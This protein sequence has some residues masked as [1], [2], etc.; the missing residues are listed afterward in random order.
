MGPAEICKFLKT[1][2]YDGRKETVKPIFISAALT[3]LFC[4]FYQMVWG[5]G[6]ADSIA[7][8]VYFYYGA[9]WATSNGRWFIRILNGFIGRNVVIP[10]VAVIG[11]VLL[12]ALAAVLIAEMLK[13][14]NKASLVLMTAMLVASPVVI[15]QLQYLYIGLSYGAAFLLS[16]LSVY[17]ILLKPA[18]RFLKILLPVLS[19]LCIT[20]MLGIYQSY[21]GAAAM[22]ILLVA[23][24]KL[25]D[26]E[27]I[28]DIFLTCLKYLGSGVTGGILDLVI[29]KTIMKLQGLE[30]AERVGTF[31]LQTI[32]GQLSDSLKNC[33]FNLFSYF[34]DAMMMRRYAYLV[35]FVTGLVLLAAGLVKLLRSGKIASFITILVLLIVLPVFI[36]ITGVIF[37]DNGITNIM[38]YQDV[39]YI[40]L[41]LA[42]L[43][44]L[45]VKKAPAEWAAALSLFFLVS[46]Y[47]ISAN[48]T[49]LCNRI[50][51]DAITHQALLMLADAYDVEEYEDGTAI[52]FAGGITDSVPRTYTGIYEYAIGTGSPVFYNNTFSME[53]SRYN[54]AYNYLGVNLQHIS[55][56][57]YEELVASEE[58]QSMPV[59]PEEGSVRYMDGC[60]VIKTR[61]Y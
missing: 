50:S 9:N 17:L 19:T 57:F 11:D 7:E 42:L 40:P 43:E 36:N 16:A 10:T 31:S 38:R 24:V 25:M 35:F 23:I 29:F 34:N 59:W 52:I 3:G 32:T 61:E 51:Y 13:I 58:F 18:G 4:Y 49:A 30:A 8:G 55:E 53:R 22:L 5:Y 12:I 45:T 1:K 6:N 27:R 14:K 41:I 54:F 46:T 28:R 21:I 48:A 33:Y 15:E 60:I 20:V 26:G 2:L 39:L 44:R 47:T 37:P 56:S